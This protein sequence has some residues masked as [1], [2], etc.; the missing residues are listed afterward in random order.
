[1]PPARMKY[2]GLFDPTCRRA[3]A[4]N[5][6]AC[7][8]GTTG[9][10]ATSKKRFSPLARL[11]F[12]KWQVFNQIAQTYRQIFMALFLNKSDKFNVLEVSHLQSPNEEKTEVGDGTLRV[13]IKLFFNTYSRT[14]YVVGTMIGAV[15]LFN[16]L[17]TYLTF[18]LLDFF[19]DLLRAY[20]YIFHSFVD[21][22]FF[23]LDW[24]MPPNLKDFIVIWT[25][26]GSIVTRWLL[27]TNLA[28][29]LYSTKSLS[30]YL[31]YAIEFYLFIFC[32]LLWPVI[33]YI[34]VGYRYPSR[35]I[36]EILL[37]HYGRPT[38]KFPAIRLLFKI[39][40]YPFSQRFKDILTLVVITVTTL[41]VCMIL[42]ALNAFFGSPPIAPNSY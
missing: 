32:F 37:R 20:R 9:R 11:F 1:M 7:N 31:S 13:L 4:F 23:W 5:A 29:P 2:R 10:A 21:V 26:S 42:I 18:P 39:N 33:I 12:A 25:V 14:F 8:P 28:W 3:K 40:P 38:E 19:R 24:K 34:F 6:A 16:L 22:V 41:I 35:Q 17:Y 36:N 27:T 30:R 15:S